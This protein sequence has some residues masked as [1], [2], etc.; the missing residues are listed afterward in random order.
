MEVGGTWVEGERLFEAERLLTFPAFRM[1]AYSKLGAYSNKYGTCQNFPTQKNPDI[2]NFKPQ[3]FFRSWSL[4]IWSTPPG[5]Q[6][7]KRSKIY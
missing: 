6:A 2:E 3:K 5:T 7:S 1:G 4:E